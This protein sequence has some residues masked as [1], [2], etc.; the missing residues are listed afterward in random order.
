VHPPSFE[1]MAITRDTTGTPDTTASQPTAPDRTAAAAVPTVNA[2][3]RGGFRRI[4][5][6]LGIDTAYVLTGFPL[7]IVAFVILV[8]GVSLGAGLLITLLGIPVLVATIYVARGFAE[9]ERVRIPAVLGRPR[10]RA[11]Y[12]SAPD[13]WRK[14]VAP[15]GD[16]QGWLDVLH[17]IVRF[18]VT[19]AAFCIV[20]TWWVTAL[21]G[22][23]VALWDWAIPRGEDN[24]DLPE[25]LGLGSDA[26]TRILFYMGVGLL[27][28][29]TLPL[30]VR[31]CALAEAWLAYAMLNGVAGLRGQVEELTGERAAAQAQTAAAV[32]AEATALRRLERDIHDGPQQR[33]VRLAV[34]LGRAQHQISTDPQAAQQTVEEALGQ[35]REALG[36]LRTLSRGIAPPILT[37]RGLP[38][39]LAALAARST[40]P[41]SL[42]VPAM[43]RLHP[44]IEQTAYFTVAEALANVAKHSQAS[45]CWVII[46]LADQMVVSVTDDGVGGAHIAKGHGLAGLADR[47][48]SAGGELRVSSP[49]GG[50][51]EI[52]AELPWPT[53]A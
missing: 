25:L 24:T 29:L 34:D 10:V 27:C 4:M 49:P 9:V 53:A 20:F 38:A 19:V 36:E 31:A 52:R 21:A 40:V 12:K 42:D 17:G 18:P 28:A 15:L 14:L 50:P 23:T 26:G 7:G 43:R 1:D 6:Q 8:T 35:A 5:R 41:V 30:V 47:L 16:G 13:G 39:A 3:E 32:S 48:H 22:L 46:E 37:D 45:R 51:T 44:L 2:P 33:L 11:H